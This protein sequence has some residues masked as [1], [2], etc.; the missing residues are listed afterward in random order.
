M[1]YIVGGKTRFG[2]MRIKDVVLSL[3]MTGYLILNKSLKFKPSIFLSIKWRGLWELNV[4]MY[5]KHWH[6]ILDILVYHF[7]IPQA[8]LTLFVGNFQV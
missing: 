7:L 2:G 5:R 1:I 6:C 4:L 8:L 3:L